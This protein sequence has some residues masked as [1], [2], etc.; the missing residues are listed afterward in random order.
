MCQ[1]F[2]GNFTHSKFT[3]KQFPFLLHPKF[4]SN[5]RKDERGM[6]WNCSSASELFS[7]CVC[8][9]Q[10]TIL[11][12][13]L[14]PSMGGFYVCKPNLF[15]VRRGC[16]WFRV[17]EKLMYPVGVGSQTLDL[18]SEVQEKCIDK[19]QIFIE[20]KQNWLTNQRLTNM[21]M[22]TRGCLV[23]LRQQ[24]SKKR[25]KMNGVRGST[26][27]QTDQ[28]WRCLVMHQCSAALKAGKQWEP[29]E[30]VKIGWLGHGLTDGW[31]V[32]W[33]D[34]WIT[35]VP[36]ACCGAEFLLGP[37]SGCFKSCW[38]M[39]VRRTHALSVCLTV[40]PTNQPTSS[41]STGY[42]L[43]LTSSRGASSPSSRIHVRVVFWKN[44]YPGPGLVWSARR[45]QWWC[46]SWWVW[47]NVVDDSNGL[48]K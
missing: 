38:P 10:V 8:V 12:K 34:G 37:V 2:M 23:E 35:W 48:C 33:L 7:S 14:R 31:M 6:K 4:K 40:C 16:Y 43:F 25:N 32:G 44:I 20:N 24:I 28:N 3:G 22:D 9:W 30:R 27:L 47:D 42:W 11:A 18:S 29:N 1:H 5:I 46:S 39:V 21:T 17:L 15:V 26:E 41:F 19:C 13:L 36:D 45:S